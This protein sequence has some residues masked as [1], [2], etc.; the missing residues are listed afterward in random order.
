M[1]GKLDYIIRGLRFVN[2]TIR[3][4]HKVI[5][6]LMLY[7]TDL[8]D[9]SCKHCLIWAKRP[10]QH[11]PLS[12]IIEIMNSKC[13]TKNTRVGFEGGEFLLHPEAN[14]ILDW[15]SKNH[16]N[17]D[18]LSNCL[19]PEKLIEAVKKYTPKRLY[20]SLDGTKET[21]LLMR[22]KDGY[23]NVLNV[24]N[25]CKDMVPISLMFTLS[26]YNNF[27]DMEH[28]IEIARE[29]NID[30]RI[31]IYGN[32]SFFETIDKAH[33]TEIGSSKNTKRLNYGDI[34]DI[35]QE[36]KVINNQLLETVEEETVEKPKQ[37]DNNF[38]KSIPKNVIDTSENYDFLLLYD[39]WRKNNLKLKCRSILD[40]IVIHPDG[41]IPICQNLGLKLGNVNDD[42]LDTIFNSMATHKIHQKHLNGCNKCWINFHRK[43]DIVLMRTMEKVLPKWFIEKM[44]GEYQWTE[45]KKTTYKEFMQA[46]S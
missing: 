14:Q 2:N 27:D 32:I 18:L 7:A 35:R 22:G 41:N 21:Y 8:C 26:P 36:E 3:P 25:S 20:I 31:G 34:K 30:V 17:F 29:N 28:V 16:P 45:N 39:E 42:S 23:D 12:K 4:K 10:A 6:T 43:Y 15:F 44:F 9:S 33:E 13:V 19:K 46:N 37:Y 24:I 11:L 38:K 5:T 40:S 1:Y